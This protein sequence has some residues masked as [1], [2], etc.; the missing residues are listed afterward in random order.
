M[1]EIQILDF[2]IGQLRTRLC[3]MNDGEFASF[4]SAKPSNHPRDGSSEHRNLC[5]GNRNFGDRQR[6]SLNWLKHFRIA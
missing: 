3:R 1:N 5:C 6:L 4:G 2:D